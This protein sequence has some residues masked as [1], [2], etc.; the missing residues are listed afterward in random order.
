MK[1]SKKNGFL[2]WQRWVSCHVLK[3][4]TLGECLNVWEKWSCHLKANN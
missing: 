2:P 3:Q 4:D 1:I